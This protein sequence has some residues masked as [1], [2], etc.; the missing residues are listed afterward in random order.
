MKRTK[1]LVR[2]KS[3]TILLMLKSRI[4]WN[5]TNSPPT[6]TKRKFMKHSYSCSIPMILGGFLEMKRRISPSLSLSNKWRKLKKWCSNSLITIMK[7]LLKLPGSSTSL[8]SS[9]KSIT[10]KWSSRGFGSKSWDFSSIKKMTQETK[11]SAAIWQ[12]PPDSS[13][14]KL[15]SNK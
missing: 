5:A 4:L 6:R 8:L 15:K 7:N 1:M 10:S 11:S 13:G 14:N 9:I 3:T 2:L 12:W